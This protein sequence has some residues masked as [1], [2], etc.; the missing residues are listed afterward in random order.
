MRQ[1]ACLV[2]YP[3][4]VVNLAALFICTPVARASHCPDLKGL[5]WLGPELLSFAWSTVAPLMIFVCFRY[6]YPEMLFGSPGIAN[7]QALSLLGLRLC[8]FIVVNYDLFVKSHL[9]RIFK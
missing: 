6:M 9:Q 7:C 1:S 3:I 5:S 2:M 4:T 8:F